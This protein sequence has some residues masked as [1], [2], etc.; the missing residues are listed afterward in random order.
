M[1]PHIPLS[2]EEMLA[3]DYKNQQERNL[4]ELQVH[5]QLICDFCSFA[6]SL[7]VQLA[8]RDFDYVETIGVLATAPL[9]VE[10]LLPAIARERD[11]LYPVSELFKTLSFDCYMPGYFVGP[12]FAVMAHS[13]FRRGH[14]EANNFAPRFIEL[15]CDLPQEGVSKYL[16]LDPNRVRI[17]INGPSYFER[18]TWFG[19]PFDREIERIPNGTV[20]L[21]PPMDVESHMIS[22][23][24][25][26]AY[27]LDIKWTEAGNIKTFQALEFKSEAITMSLDG[28]TYFP[29]RYIHAEYDIAIGSFRHF[30]GALQLYTKDEYFQRRD[31]DFNHN[32]KHP[33]H[34]KARSN[35]LFKLNGTI[36][37]SQWVEL[38][39]HFLAGNPLAIEYFSGHYPPQVNEALL[40][41]QSR[42]N[43]KGKT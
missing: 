29:A 38:C 41:L 30:D 6:S 3:N 33:L 26:D 1:N 22:F 36:T 34:L 12:N 15:F 24:F 40:K 18:D 13:A 17:D 9:L 20:K 19:A 11:N 2:Q 7:G 5:S 4:A 35:K 43:E 27:S 10:K 14:H 28:S 23:F 37:V 16:A 25:A 31:S 21:K 8:H 42:A 39:C 32:A